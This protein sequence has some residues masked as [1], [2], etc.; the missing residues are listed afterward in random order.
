MNNAEFYAKIDIFYS[1]LINIMQTKGSEY[2]GSDDKFAN[3]KR[4]A[5]M[6]D[7]P[8]ESIWL[9]Y[10]MKHS[11]SLV[12]FIRRINKGESV[13]SIEATLSEPISGRIG[14]MINY[15][16]ILKGIIDEH[17][18]MESLD[19]RFEELNEKAGLT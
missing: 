7:I 9:T 3:F 17:R 2:S 13:T 18:L 15:L 10:F 14:D 8:M 11:D 19:K 16:F 12:S 6:Q 4:L 5:K 1:E